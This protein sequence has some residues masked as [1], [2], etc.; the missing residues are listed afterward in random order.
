[1]NSGF[2]RI[3]KFEKQIH[4]IRRE[5]LFFNIE[6]RPKP[7]F[8]HRRESIFEF[9]ETVFYPVANVRSGFPPT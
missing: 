5:T 6:S 4:R 9:K 8:P 3:R 2:I 7:S 1:M